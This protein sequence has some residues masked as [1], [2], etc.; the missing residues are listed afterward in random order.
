MGRS[1]FLRASSPNAW[2][3][4]L[5]RPWN[6]LAN[7]PR[8]HYSTWRCLRLQAGRNVHPVTVEVITV[9]DQVAEM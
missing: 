4:T 8:D 2:R 5:S 1:I 3:L 6:R 7:C 9:H